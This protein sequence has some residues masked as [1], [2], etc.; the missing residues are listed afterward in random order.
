[1]SRSGDLG[2]RGGRWS[3]GESKAECTHA[4]VRQGVRQDLVISA[5]PYMFISAELREEGTSQSVGLVRLYYE[6]RLLSKGYQRNIVHDAE[7]VSM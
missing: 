3:V 5:K 7:M 2:V 1:M 4:N 6:T